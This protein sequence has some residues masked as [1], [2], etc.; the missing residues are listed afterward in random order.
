MGRSPIDKGRMTVNQDLFAERKVPAFLMELMVERH[1]GIGRLR[2]AQD[3]S[4]FGAGLA[5]CLAAAVQ[6]R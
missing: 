5:K 2:T 3:F 6:G 1:P 4:D